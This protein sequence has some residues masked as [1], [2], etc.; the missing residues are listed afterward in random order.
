M[1]KLEK[2]AKVNFHKS[3]SGSIAVKVII[4]KD[5]AEH[6]ELQNGDYV[7]FQANNFGKAVHVVKEVSKNE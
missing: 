7:V 3:G 2:K 1:I 4:P 5:I 6:M